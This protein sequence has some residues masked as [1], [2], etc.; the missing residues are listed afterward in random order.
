MDKLIQ[1]LINQGIITSD[2]VKRC[3]T[4]ELLYVIINRVNELNGLTK[5]ALEEVQDLINKMKL[6]VTDQLETWEIDGTMSTLINEIALGEVNSNVELT[7]TQ[8][9][10]TEKELNTRIDSIIALPEGSTKADAELT[11]IRL[12]TTGKTYT[13][14]GTAVRTQIANAN[15]K[16][17][18][19]NDR[20]NYKNLLDINHLTQGI[21]NLSGNQLTSTQYYFTDFIPFDSTMSLQL[22]RA[23]NS[24]LFRATTYN[25]TKMRF[26][27]AYDIN[28]EVLST[29]G[30]ENVETA[31]TTSDEKVKYVRVTLLSGYV[32]EA[33]NNT[34]LTYGSTPPEKY[35][36]IP[37][38]YT[39]DGL[40]SSELK[41]VGK[42]VLVLGDSIAYGEGSSGSGIASILAEKYGCLTENY[43][44]SGAT[45]IDSS[46]SI[47]QQYEKIITD[48]TSTA[49][50]CN[51]DYIIFD[52][53]ANDM[54]TDKLSELGTLSEYYG[55]E[56]TT[57]NFTGAF[58]TLIRNLQTK[59]PQAKLIYF[60]NHR[61]QTRN[62]V[63][64]DTYFNRAKEIMQKYGVEVVDI[65]SISGLN[66]CIGT[67]H[68][69]YCPDKTHPNK[70]GYLKFYIP[71]IVDAMKKCLP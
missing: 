64:M 50:V 55:N 57:D 65:T 34:M 52:G 14:A 47:L 21:I 66:T 1:A 5:E 39:L 46:N 41:L 2:D 8:L 26:V 16:I 4:L 56:V 49:F 31:F 70:D 37:Y 38:G 40:L 68:T 30:G 32:V 19:I 43:A 58:E 25:Q 6:E 15:D 13:S 44:V 33:E 67:Q 71:Y 10:Q 18:N 27:T 48:Y 35:E 63:N 61:M 17:K 60:T 11:D 22:L 53:G 28:K 3:S 62:K 9:K 12:S 20:F 54:V 42:R 36:Y 51:P 29:S 45:V 69:N 24:N 59:F 23:N 7:K